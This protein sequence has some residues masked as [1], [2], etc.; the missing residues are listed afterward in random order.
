MTA[1]R[2]GG[3]IN[4]MRRHTPWLAPVALMVALLVFSSCGGSA[5]DEAAT[6]SLDASIAG[7]Y[8][9]VSTHPELIQQLPCYCGCMTTAGHASLFDCYYDA[10]GTY[11]QHASRCGVCL[12][13]VDIAQSL[14][15]DGAGVTEIR[16]TIDDTFTH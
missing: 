13:E 8:I 11:D 16:A 5:T 15:A 7:R 12:G 10:Q 14:L 9:F 4:V 1:R 3:L 6:A 2:A